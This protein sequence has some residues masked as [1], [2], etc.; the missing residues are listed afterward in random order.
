MLKPSG[1]PDPGL[2]V[3]GW[4]KRGPTGIIGEKAPDYSGT[5]PALTAVAGCNNSH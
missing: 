3:V 2:Y 5:V 4:A 1:D